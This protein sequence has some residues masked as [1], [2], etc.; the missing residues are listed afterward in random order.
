[1]SN[2]H[3]VGLPPLADRVSGE[4]RMTRERYSFPY[5]V[6]ADLDAMIETFPE[7][8]D[9][10]HPR[11]YE[12]ISTDAYQKMRFAEYLDQAAA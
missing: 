12:T 9:A 3:R 2:R 10:T 6:A 8:I 7:C 1:M 5:F 4:Q 11:K